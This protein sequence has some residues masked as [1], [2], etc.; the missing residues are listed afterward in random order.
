M[1]KISIKEILAHKDS[2]CPGCKVVDLKSELRVY[3]NLGVHNKIFCGKLASVNDKVSTDNIDEG[4]LE[5]YCSNCDCRFVV[6]LNEVVKMLPG[7]GRGVNY[8]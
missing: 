2:P 6:D 3:F 4:S 7:S 8:E 5:A 1:K